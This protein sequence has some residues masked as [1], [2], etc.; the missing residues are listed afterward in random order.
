MEGSI[1]NCRCRP[2]TPFPPSSSC[3]VPTIPFRRL[4]PFLSQKQLDPWFFCS[5]PS[6]FP[7]LDLMGNRQYPP[8]LKCPLFFIPEADPRNIP[9]FPS[10]SVYPRSVKHTFLPVFCRRLRWHSLVGFSSPFFS[11]TLLAGKETVHNFSPF[12]NW[13]NF[14]LT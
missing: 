2:E 7:Y 12:S 1:D 10:G 5:F 11:Q 9:P 4:F 13:S 6:L 3:K 14:R 8:H